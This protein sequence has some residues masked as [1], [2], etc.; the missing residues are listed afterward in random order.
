MDQSYNVAPFASYKH[1]LA[2]TPVNG[3]LP[4][5]DASGTAVISMAVFVG[6]AGALKVIM[7]DGAT[8]TFA[9]VPAGT[10]IPIQITQVLLTGTVATSIVALY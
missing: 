3:V 2:I 8:V 10:T 9:A 6:G 7:A 5:T 4:L 1:A